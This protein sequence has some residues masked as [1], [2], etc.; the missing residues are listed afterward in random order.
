MGSLRTSEKLN[1]VRLTRKRCNSHSNR[2]G[3][4][5]I[6]NETCYLLKRKGLVTK[7]ADPRRWLDGGRCCGC[8]QNRRFHRFC[9]RKLVNLYSQFHAPLHGPYTDAA[10]ESEEKPERP[11]DTPILKP[12]Q[13]ANNNLLSSNV[14]GFT[15]AA[16]LIAALNR[17][18]H[19]H[20]QSS[21]C[22]AGQR[23]KLRVFT[24]RRKDCIH[25]G[26]HHLLGAD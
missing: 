8:G 26:L 12:L 17:R 19:W 2:A 14:C 7:S 18:A 24:Q 13:A 15:P 6:L 22:A 11:A 25:P 16:S 3:V 21:I 5:L 1:A 20:R 9:L 23:H 4:T 10:L